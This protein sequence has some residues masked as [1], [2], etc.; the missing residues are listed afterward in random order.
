M[1]RYVNELH[2]PLAYYKKSVPGRLR[3]RRK[4]PR[5]RTK[6][7]R[8]DRMKRKWYRRRPMKQTQEFRLVGRTYEG[9]NVI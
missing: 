1:S 3:N 8:S 9:N 5:N 7:L 4:W 6:G 2:P